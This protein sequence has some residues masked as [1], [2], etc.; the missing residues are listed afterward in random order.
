[1]GRLLLGAAP[2]VAYGFGGK[3]KEKYDGDTESGKL[4]F[5]GDISDD[6][7]DN[8]K[9]DEYYYGKPLDFGGNLLAGYEFSNKLSVQLTPQLGMAN[10]IP[11]YSGKKTDGSVKNV[12]FGISLGYKF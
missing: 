12:G 4:K 10:L 3:W 2:Y 8:L 6:D 11:K 7:L 5:K 9:D 1:M